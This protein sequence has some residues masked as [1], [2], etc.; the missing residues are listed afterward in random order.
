MVDRVGFSI[1]NRQAKIR[2]TGNEQHSPAIQ[3]SESQK[4]SA[5]GAKATMKRVYPS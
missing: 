4:A 3:L 2:G 5:T 1:D